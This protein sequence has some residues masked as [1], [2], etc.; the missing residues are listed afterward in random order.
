MSVEEPEANGFGDAKII[1]Y[2]RL[3]QAHTRAE[4]GEEETRRLE[5]RSARGDERA[6]TRQQSREADLGIL[7]RSYR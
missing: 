4:D 1:L 7:P 6:H 3:P 2:K 5:A